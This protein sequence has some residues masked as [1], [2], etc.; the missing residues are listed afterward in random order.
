MKILKIIVGLIF[1][2]VYSYE[3]KAQ[4][5]SSMIF[6]IGAGSYVLYEMTDLA[7][8]IKTYVLLADNKEYEQISDNFT[9]ITAPSIEDLI[10]DL[11]YFDEFL[12]K[13]EEGTSDIF[14]NKSISVSSIM[15]AKMLI[16]SPEDRNDAYCTMH[17][18]L[19]S[20]MRKKI[21]KYKNQ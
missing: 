12:T 17:P 5:K 7:T 19:T 4:T 15:G 21:E 6:N 2:F 1:L 9:L 8:N 18:G 20:K 16:I 10:S 13:Y 11:D 14:K 3:L